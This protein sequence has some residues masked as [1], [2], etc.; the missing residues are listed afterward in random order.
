[1]TRLEIRGHLN[2]T[3]LYMGDEFLAVFATWDA[4]V[5]AYRVAVRM[6]EMK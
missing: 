6:G 5:A 2:G 3:A 4:A 1:M